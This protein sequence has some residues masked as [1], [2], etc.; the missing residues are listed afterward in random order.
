MAFFARAEPAKAAES[1]AA[2]RREARF[3]V[4]F[5][6]LLPTRLNAQVYSMIQ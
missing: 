6:L 4:S 1:V 2:A 3:L 5:L